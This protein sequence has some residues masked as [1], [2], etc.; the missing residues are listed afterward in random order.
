MIKGGRTGDNDM[1]RDTLFLLRPDFMDG[2][3]GPYFCPG[4]AELRGLLEFYPALK[5]VLDVRHVEFPRPR[6]ELVELV[7]E[8]NQSCPVLVLREPK[9]IS[10]RSKVTPFSGVTVNSK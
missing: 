10:E 4:C 6:P 1:E 8:E 3:R 7:G 9:E 5:R 2:D